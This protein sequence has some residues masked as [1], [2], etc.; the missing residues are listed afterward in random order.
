MPLTLTNEQRLG[1]TGLLSKQQPK[2]LKDQLVNFDL[3]RKIELDETL[4]SSCLIHGPNGQVKLDR[5][6]ADQTSTIELE[7]AEVRALLDIIEASDINVQ[8]VRWL[9]PLYKM[10]KELCP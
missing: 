3:L 6:I 2:K 4:A 8:D 5:T 7:K 1:V 9:N 10:C